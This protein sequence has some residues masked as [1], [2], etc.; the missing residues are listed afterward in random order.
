MVAYSSRRMKSRFSHRPEKFTIKRP[1]SF[2]VQLGKPHLLSEERFRQPQCSRS[3]AGLQ[4][5]YLRQAFSSSQA[6]VRSAIPI[7]EKTLIF[8][9]PTKFNLR[10]SQTETSKRF[11]QK[12]FL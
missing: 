2:Q 4:L 6:K 11:V 1:L 10:T 12:A 8:T 7:C 9:N 3:A 5:P